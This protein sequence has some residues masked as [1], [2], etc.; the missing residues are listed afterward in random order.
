MKSLIDHPVELGALRSSHHIVGGLPFLPSEVESVYLRALAEWSAVAVDAWASVELGDT[1]GGVIVDRA[2]VIL[3]CDRCDLDPENVKRGLGLDDITQLS[4]QR[5][6]PSVDSLLRVQDAYQDD[7]DRDG[8]AFSSTVDL[9]S[10]HVV[11][12]VELPRQAPTPDSELVEVRDGFQP[13]WGNVDKDSALGFNLVEGGQK[14]VSN[15]STAATSGFAVQSAFGPFILTAGHAV[16]T[17]PPCNGVGNTWTQGGLALGVAAT[18]QFG[19][20][21]DAA[22]ISTYGYRNN[23][24]RVHYTSSDHLHPITFPWTVQAISGATVCQTGFRTTGISGND[25][26]VNRCGVVDSILANPRTG[27]ASP[28]T[29]ASYGHA[30]YWCQSGDSGAS[31]VWP[32][33]FGFGAVGIHSAGAPTSGA[34]NCYFTRFDL[35]A[36]MWGLSL[37]PVNL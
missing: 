37:S 9:R 28:P 27:H 30:N 18:C 21:I 36:Q 10:G 17:S 8:I 31:I 22:L 12:L 11:F 35:I 3:L 16:G 24:G 1:Y 19:G 34:F 4:I 26:V 33:A 7:L 32:T 6:S 25:A 5:D 13:V 15:A 2:H 14:I 23:I 29:T 20:S